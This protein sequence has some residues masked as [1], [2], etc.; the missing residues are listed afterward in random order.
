MKALQRSSQSCVSSSR[1]RVRAKNGVFDRFSIK[2]NEK[3]SIASVLT[4]RGERS[5]ISR[6]PL[7]AA[8]T[9]PVRSELGKRLRT[10]NLIKRADFLVIWSLPLNKTAICPILSLL[11]G[12][13]RR[14]WPKNERKTNRKSNGDQ[15]A[16]QIVRGGRDELTS[17]SISDRLLKNRAKSR[18]NRREMRFCVE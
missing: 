6:S 3:K 17:S 13:G 18:A 4:E 8:L 1:R 2:R 11:G 15:T 16:T 12:L 10:L 5:P 7:Q 9:A 14:F